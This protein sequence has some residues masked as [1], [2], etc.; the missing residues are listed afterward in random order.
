MTEIQ[1]TII[2]MNSSVVGHINKLNRV[3]EKISKLNAMLC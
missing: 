3:K 2:E 1:H